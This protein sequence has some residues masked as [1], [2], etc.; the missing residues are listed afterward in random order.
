MLLSFQ[1]YESLVCAVIRP[2][3]SRYTPENDLGPVLLRL[4]S[5]VVMERSDFTLKNYQG[6]TLQCSKWI[7]AAGG[8]LR[9]AVVYL[10][11]NSS[12]RVDATRTGVLETVGPMNAALVAFDFSGSGLSDGDFVTLGWHEH[13][14]VG[15]VVRH[16]K[17][18]L[19]F[20]KVPDHFPWLP[21]HNM[22]VRFK[23]SL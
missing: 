9:T 6:H 4:D 15:T 11:G 21:S 16:L 8:A 18:E 2:P 10:H 12:C 5:G 22:H 13:H 14:D 7:P 20:E 19:G 1:G 3:R 17:E 23:T